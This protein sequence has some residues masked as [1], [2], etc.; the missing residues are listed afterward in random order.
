MPTEKLDTDVDIDLKDFG[1]TLSDN[2][3]KTVQMKNAKHLMNGMTTNN[4]NNDS[5]NV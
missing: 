5:F 1:S 4:D 3:N 2:N